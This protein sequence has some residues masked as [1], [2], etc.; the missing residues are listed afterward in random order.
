[1]LMPTRIGNHWLLVEIEPCREKVRVYDSLRATDEGTRK[2]REDV[3]NAIRMWYK[4]KDGDD[5]QVQWEQVPQQ[6]NGEDCG[7]AMLLAM[8]RRMLI[9]RRPR[10]GQGWDY[11]A[12]DFEGMRWKVAAELSED[13]IWLMGDDSMKRT[14][15]I[16]MV[17]KI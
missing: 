2:G 3:V 9:K 6:E 10:G 16:M 7:V 12:Q 13:R 1:M 15:R 8:R 11:S 4:G 17:E 14:R 5:M